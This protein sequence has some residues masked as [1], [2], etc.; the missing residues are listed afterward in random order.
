MT[1]DEMRDFKLIRIS[2]KKFNSYVCLDG[3]LFVEDNCCARRKKSQGYGKVKLFVK[4]IRWTN[5]SW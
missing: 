1:K 2:M 3:R 4:L 5:H